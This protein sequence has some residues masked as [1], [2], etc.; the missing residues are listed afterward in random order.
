M[1]N[2]ITLPAPDDWHAHFRFGEMLKDVVPWS[3]KQ[4]RRCIAMGNV[5]P[6]ETVAEAQAYDDECND[7]SQKFGC[8]TLVSPKLIPTTTPYMVKEFSRSYFGRLKL[9]AGITTGSKGGL[10][11]FR[12]LYSCLEVMQD[13]DMVL[14]IH[15]E[16]ADPAVD[17]DQRERS[18][19]PKVE[20]LSDD[21]PT[22]RIVVEHISCRETVEFVRRMHE[23]TRPVAATVTLAHLKHN[24]NDVRGGEL[25]P[26][27]IMKPEIQGFADQKAIMELVYESRPPNVFFGSDS[28]PHPAANKGPIKVANGGFTAPVLMPEL[29]RLFQVH[30]NPDAL[31]NFTSVFGA[32][33]YRLPRNKEKLVLIR[34]PWQVPE[35][36]GAVR[37]YMAGQ[38]LEWQVDGFI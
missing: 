35:M 21:F 33:F 17:C 13:C 20:Q 2:E 11:D 15:A 22:L 25:E 38:T 24:K 8:T 32:D 5:P 23:K 26:Q 12:P 16:D 31:A 6:I 36:I 3:A 7:Q 28:A 4:F 18:C 1:K 30:A 34:K 29:V 10:V 9:Y 37:P 19:L 14:Q 27:L